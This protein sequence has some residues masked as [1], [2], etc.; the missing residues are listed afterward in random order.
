METKKSKDANLEN[1]KFA[2][3]AIGLVM[4]SS[5]VLMAFNYADAEI[6][7]KDDL[8]DNSGLSEE[9]VYELPEIEEEIIEEEEPQVIPP[10]IIND[11]V[12]VDDDDDYDDID[13]GDI[14]DEYDPDD[15]CIGCE[16]DIEDEEPVDWAEVEP[17]F[18]G[19]EGE[20][21]KFIQDNIQFTSIDTE[22]GNGGIVYVQ[23]V[24]NKDGSI[25]DVTVP[26]GVSEGVNKSA[27]D[28]VKKM[29][30]WTAGEQAGKKV[31][32]KFTLPINVNF[33]GL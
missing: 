10:V 33:G 21:A 6:A 4:I 31:R 1:K 8:T 16:E 32:C 29:P 3:F 15:E 11:I 23:F 20:M 2:F 12:I 7:P 30:R 19:G 24:V 9:F 5:L 14:E 17:A 25:V 18:P 13:F 27:M 26:R 28:V 22:L